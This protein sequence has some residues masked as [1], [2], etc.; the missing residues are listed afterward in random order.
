MPLD[1][2]ATLL[3]RLKHLVLVSAVFMEEVTPLPDIILTVYGGRF[4]DIEAAIV[5]HGVK[6]TVYRV[7]H[8]RYDTVCPRNNVA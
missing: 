1:A 3:T 4:E 7:Q 2:H 8:H 5:L 6:G